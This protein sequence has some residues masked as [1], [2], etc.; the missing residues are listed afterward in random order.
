MKILAKIRNVPWFSLNLFAKPDSIA[1][2]GKQST[3]TG[4]LQLLRGK[5]FTF[6]IVECL[7]TFLFY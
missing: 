4:I 2:L 6:Q 7:E 3:H 1:K 5:K